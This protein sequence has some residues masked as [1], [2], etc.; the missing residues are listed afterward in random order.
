MDADGSHQTRL[1]HDGA[2]DSTP[3]WSPDGMKIAFTS[4]QSGNG[5]VWKIDR[6]GSNATQITTDP[7]FDGF[8]DWSAG[9]DTHRVPERAVRQL[10][11]LDRAAVRRWA[12][13]GHQERIG[14]PGSGLVA[15][16]DAD[17]VRQRQIREPGH[18]HGPR[19][20]VGPS[21]GDH[22]PLPGHPSGVGA[23]GQPDRVREQPGRPAIAIWTA[24]A[25]GGSEKRISKPGHERRTTRPAWRVA[26]A[27]IVGRSRDSTREHT[28]WNRFEGMLRRAT[29]PACTRMGEHPEGHR[30]DRSRRRQRPLL[31]ER[32][33]PPRGRCHHGRL[34]LDDG[35]RQR[36]D[37][38]AS[39]CRR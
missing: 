14:G 9:R 29:S 37:A 26:G 19:G 25:G 2:N 11:H 32:A 31:D 15:R 38:P 39:T 21:P 36:A 34:A 23:A 18:L 6:D 12:S 7:A 20:R 10:R 3:A 4:D 30:H 22:Q 24:L 5:D 28:G 1:T 17:R 27:D 35:R 13:A 8:P 33:D 16:R